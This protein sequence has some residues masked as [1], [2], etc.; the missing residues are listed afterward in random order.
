MAK[1]TLTIDQKTV[2]AEPGDPL[3]EV[4]KKAGVYIP[5]LC[6]MDDLPSYGG[7]RLCA[8]EIEGVRGLPLACTTQVTDGM[9]VR[10]DT[11]PVRELQRGVMETI[12]SEHPDRCLTCHRKIHCLP[13][14]I[15]LRD[16]VVTDR[17]VTCAKNQWCELQQ[18][19]EFLGM[20]GTGRFYEEG[21]SW[22]G[23]REEIPLERENPFIERDYNKCILCARCVRVCDEVR[24]VG[25]ISVTYKGDKARIDTPFGIPLHETNCELCGACVDVCPTASLMDKTTKWAGLPDKLVSTICPYCGTGCQL[26]LHVKGERIVRV[27]ADAEGAV[28]KGQACVKGRYGLDFVH[29]PERLTTPLIRDNGAF[30]EA[31]WDEA[32]DLVASR[33][34]DYRGEE[35]AAIASS[36]CTNEDCYILQKFARVV[37]GSNNVDHCAR[38]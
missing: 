8:V 27:S 10:T 19:S 29:H 38:L 22:Y 20:E 14:W 36:K 2:E 7:C 31:S 9:V 23:A 30:R 25:A 28:N 34:G 12:L 35:F 33:L 6:Y 3:L 17:C 18:V 4:A 37:M 11:A 24:G 21:R 1:V 5:H 15:C 16:D 26:L 32:L 13:N